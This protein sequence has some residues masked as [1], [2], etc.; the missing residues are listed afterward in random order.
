MKVTKFIYIIIAF[1]LVKSF[2]N[3]FLAK[4]NSPGRGRY[5]HPYERRALNAREA[6]QIQGIPDNFWSKTKFSKTSFAK[7]IGDAVPPPIIFPIIAS[8]FRP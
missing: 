2:H 8:L 5:V 3:L 7:L 4:D 6:S 1:L